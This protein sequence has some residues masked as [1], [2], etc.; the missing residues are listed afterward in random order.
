MIRIA[1]SLP[2][3]AGSNDWRRDARLKGAEDQAVK[4]S[5]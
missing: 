1:A 4:I 3:E 5:L 2:D